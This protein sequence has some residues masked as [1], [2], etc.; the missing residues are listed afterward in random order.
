M[1]ERV[2]QLLSAHIETAIAVADQ[3]PEQIVQAGMRLTQ[4]L[5]AEGKLLLCA[6]G[7]AYANG[8]HFI[9]SMLNRYEVERPPLPVMMLGTHVPLLHSL[10]SERHDDQ[11]FARE[12]QA[13][14]QPQDI[15]LVLSASGNAPSL[16]QALH[17]AKEKGMDSIVVCG[18]EGGILTHHI[19]PTDCIVRIPTR[20]PSRIIEL[21]LV[22]LHGFCEVIDS[23]LFAQME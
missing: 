9:S 10:V 2:I 16:V 3:L 20:D 1:E 14:G 23:A 22:V 17:A 4:S 15:L 8:Q 12:I 7:R 19:G 5:L 11:V 18:E 6:H 21:Q 13:L